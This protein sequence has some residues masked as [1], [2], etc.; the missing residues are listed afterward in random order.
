MKACFRFESKLAA[1]RRN[2]MSRQGSANF[3]RNGTLHVLLMHV[4]HMPEVFYIRFT[5]I[6]VY[7]TFCFTLDEKDESLSG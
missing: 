3:D 4:R 5:L 2:S 6:G 7:G 1:L